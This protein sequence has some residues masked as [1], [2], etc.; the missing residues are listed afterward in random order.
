MLASQRL[1]GATCD[2]CLVEFLFF[3]SQGEGMDATSLFARQCRY[4]SRVNAST[5]KHANRYVSNKMLANTV[6]K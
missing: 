4:R 5:Q 1:C 3:E 2:R 6:C